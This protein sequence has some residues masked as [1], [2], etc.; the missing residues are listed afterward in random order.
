MFEQGRDLYYPIVQNIKIDYYIGQTQNLRN[1]VTLRKE[2]IKHEQ[3]RHLPESKHLHRCNNGMFR[4]MPIYQ[5]S[6]NNRIER[7]SKE[8][9][10]VSILEPKLNAC[11]STYAGFFTSGIV[12]T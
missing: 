7:E 2:Q 4:I 6:N 11:N 3:Y 5:C 12:G 8:S 10:I 1:R 9:N